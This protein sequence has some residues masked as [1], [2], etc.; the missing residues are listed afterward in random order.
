MQSILILFILGSLLLLSSIGSAET[1][2]ECQKRCSAEKASKD[3]NCPTP[4]ETS[5]RTNAAC[6][7]ENQATF[8]NCLNGCP[9]PEP[10]DTPEAK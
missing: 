10:T 4:E 6:L 8:N 1:N 3:E 9:E 7:Q 5:E 2:A